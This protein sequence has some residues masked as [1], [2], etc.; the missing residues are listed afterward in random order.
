MRAK[1]QECVGARFDDFMLL[2]APNRIEPVEK[3]INPAKYFLYADCFMSI[4]QSIEKAEYA[5]VYASLVRKL[6][7][8]AKRTEEYAYLFENLANLEVLN[9]WPVPPWMSQNLYNQILLLPLF[10][11]Q[12][13]I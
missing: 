13:E 9:P 2:D 3:V 7:Y 1:F 10:F 8:A 5:K 4:F 11:P 12:S 6:K